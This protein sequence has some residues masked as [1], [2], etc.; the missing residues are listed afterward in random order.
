MV[1]ATG[2]SSTI[3]HIIALSRLIRPL[4]MALLMAMLAIVLTLILSSEA[5][6]GDL[7]THEPIV[8]EGDAN[9]TSANGVVSGTGAQDDPYMIEGWDISTSILPGMIIR[10]TT[11]HFVIRDCRFNG[12]SHPYMVAIALQQVTGVRIENITTTG[13]T[14]GIYVRETVDIDVTNVTMKGALEIIDGR[15]VN[16]SRVVLQGEGGVF[17]IYTCQDV[18]VTDCTAT[19]AD[20]DT[21]G[22]W[23]QN[24]YKVTAERCVV[25]HHGIG[26]FASSFEGAVVTDC[27]LTNN[28]EVDLAVNIP[29]AVLSNNTMGPRGLLLDWSHYYSIDQS[30]TVS[31]RPVRY[32]T[33]ISSLEI[34]DDAEIGQLL[35]FNVNDIQLRNLTFHG[36]ALPIGV[37]GAQE[38]TI[39]NLTAVNGTGGIVIREATDLTLS[40]VIIQ[41]NTTSQHSYRVLN[42]GNVDNVEI[43]RCTFSGSDLH[44]VSM[45]QA[46]TAYIQDCNLSDGGWGVY[47]D[48]YSNAVIGLSNVTIEN[49]HRGVEVPMAQRLSVLDCRMIENAYSGIKADVDEVTVRNCTVVNS[50]KGIELR[51]PEKVTVSEVTVT[52]ST[53]YGMTIGPTDGRTRITNCTIQGGWFG[54]ELGGTSPRVE[55]VSI[56]GCG[57]GIYMQA[58]RSYT[59]AVVISNCSYVGYAVE[60]ES[61]ILTRSHITNCGIGVRIEDSYL[62]L[63]FSNITSCVKGIAIWRGSGSDIYYNEISECSA[64]GIEVTVAGA[65]WIH[66]N[67]LYGNFYDEG[68]GTYR[69]PQVLGFPGNRFD[70]NGYGNYYS[71][72]T[73]WYPNATLKN[74]RVWD[75]PYKMDGLQ[76]AYDYNP[77]AMPA[78]WLPPTAVPGEDQTVPQ[79]TT[80]QLDGSASTDDRGVTEHYWTFEYDGEEFNLTGATASFTFD[81]PGT[82]VVT[83]TVEDRWGNHDHRVLNVTVLDTQVPVLDAGEDVVVDMGVNFA[84]SPTTCHDN[85]GVIDYLWTLVGEGDE[86]TYTT[87]AVLVN[88]E[89]PGVYEATLNVTDGA[90]NHATDTL[91]VTVRDTEPPIAQPGEDIQVV[92]HSLFTINGLGSTDNVAVVNWTWTISGPGDD[93]V[94]YGPTHEISFTDA[95]NFTVLLTVF[96]DRGNNASASFV[97]TVVDTEPPVAVAGDDIVTDQGKNVELDGSGSSDNV[98]ITL[99]LWTVTYNDLVTE[100]T[101]PFVTFNFEGPGDFIVT[102]SVS[103]LQGNVGTD[104]VLVTVRDITPPIADAGEDV[105]VD[106]H[107][108]VTF[109]GWASYDN[110]EM[111][112]PLWTFEYDGEG[113][114]LL[115]LAPDFIFDIVGEYVVT[116]T[117]EDDAGNQAEDTMT[118]TVLDTE[119]PVA[120]A[121]GRTP[122]WED[123]PGFLNASRS[124]DNVGIVS[125]TWTF[126]DGRGDRTLKGEMVSHV[127][128]EMGEYEVTLTVEDARGNSDTDTIT[129]KVERMHGDPPPDDDDGGLSLAVVGA[130]VAAIVAALLVALLLMRQRTRAE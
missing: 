25:T 59:S 129:V 14:K 128:N 92:Q 81:L 62:N 72:Y 83:L 29:N 15:Y 66:M 84:L 87:R 42:T 36:V 20:T 112:L 37:M 108:T 91:T 43:T 101:G 7:T 110:V 68:T 111:K 123:D 74:R 4:K 24:S 82:Y 106:Q 63:T 116:F 38:V 39:E 10:Q 109:D 130:I 31:G 115:G 97:V 80:I 67:N 86:W 58:D 102:L 34:D 52:G 57:Y 26:V 94:L 1:V 113:Q 21:Y 76:V 120:V 12:G 103:D 51:S 44:L 122:F 64:H 95:G 17:E 30:N 77:L 33:N 65:N 70:I 54:I 61:Q 98:G 107:T 11:K 127:F 9:F 78:D 69:Y 27:V 16:I 88:L 35:A 79:N 53:D 73:Q 85:V 93:K 60:G 55:N 47:F 2:E 71:D 49:A 18:R 124:T 5:V 13:G 90:G 48:G 125:W 118:V 117:V 56:E 19:G 114:E 45:Y 126:N 105:T 99:Y 28:T 22:I 41:L 104:T 96:D 89:V 46:R 3:S 6:E 119:S 23:F 100:R 121:E 32:V 40:D 50:T 75:T 8:I